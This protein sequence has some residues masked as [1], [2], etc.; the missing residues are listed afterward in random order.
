MNW[1]MISSINLY[2]YNASFFY[3][4]CVSVSECDR[5]TKNEKQLCYKRD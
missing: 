3:I 1:I 4:V 5:K 2:E